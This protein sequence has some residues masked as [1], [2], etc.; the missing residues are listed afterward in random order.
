M[1]PPFTGLQHKDKQIPL[2]CGYTLPKVVGANLLRVAG[3]TEGG[4]DLAEVGLSR[5][6]IW[7]FLSWKNLLKWIWG[8]PYDIYDLGNLHM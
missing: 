6:T 8:Y 7:G 3:F 1:I 5:Y 4:A 2:P